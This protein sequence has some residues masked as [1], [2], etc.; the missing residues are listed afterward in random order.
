V[1]IGSVA[2]G[3]DVELI[4]GQVQQHWNARLNWGGDGVRAWRSGARRHVWREQAGAVMCC[5]RDRGV[6]ENGEL[7]GFSEVSR[8]LPRK[9]G[10]VGF[11][12]GLAGLTAGFA[13]VLGSVM[14]VLAGCGVCGNLRWGF[15]H[16]PTK[17]AGCRRRG[18]WW[19]RRVR[20]VLGRVLMGVRQVAGVLD[21]GMWG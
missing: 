13:V 11:V 10:G 3:I 9:P 21:E 4:R 18:G 16:L 19:W 2:S 20:R 1:Q 15:R 12:A 8:H 6:V 7:A 17:P 14:A 5:G